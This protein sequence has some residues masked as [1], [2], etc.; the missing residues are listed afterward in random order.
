MESKKIVSLAIISLLS[1]SK[2]YSCIGCISNSYNLKE[3]G[4]PKKSHYVK[5]CKCQCEKYMAGATRGICPNCRHYHEPSK[6]GPLAYYELIK[7]FNINKPDQSAKKSIEEQI[8]AL[9][10]SKPKSS[11][12][13]STK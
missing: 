4:D 13:K 5:T 12:N 1:F 6:F 9:N 7:K 3:K 8:A 11:Q 2:I 10:I